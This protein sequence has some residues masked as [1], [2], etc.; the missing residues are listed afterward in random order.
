MR[1]KPIVLLLV[2][3][4]EKDTEDAFPEYEAAVHI[5]L[6]FTFPVICFPEEIVK[7]LGNSTGPLSLT[8]VMEDTLKVDI[9]PPYT[10]TQVLPA[11]TVTVAPTDTVIG[12][13]A[14]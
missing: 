1:I 14:P 6:K 5:P 8:F 13:N 10:M 3:L 9:N 4:P 12:P 7:P 11:P 2:I